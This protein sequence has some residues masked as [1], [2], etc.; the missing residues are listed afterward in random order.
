MIDTDPTDTRNIGKK[1]CSKNYFFGGHSYKCKM[2]NGMDADFARENPEVR[3][4][5]IEELIK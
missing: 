1:C 2:V 4:I 5:K 3:D